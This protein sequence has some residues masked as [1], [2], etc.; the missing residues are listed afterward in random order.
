MALNNS[1]PISLGGATVG[2]SINLELG[3]AATA[4]ASIN[5]T[6]FRTLANVPSGTITLSNFYGKSSNSYW[7]L[8]SALPTLGTGFAVSVNGILCI[9]SGYPGG[10]VR[11]RDIVFFGSDGAFLKSTATNPPLNVS[12]RVQSFTNNISTSAPIFYANI[13]DEFGYGQ[14]FGSGGFA[15]FN[16]T[17]NTN[18]FPSNA[19]KRLGT[20]TAS[21]TD[22]SKR[23]L[24]VDASGNIYIVP[25]YPSA[26]TGKSFIYRSAYASLTSSGTERFSKA[27]S[28]GTNVSSFY[29]N[30]NYG[31]LRSDNQLV[32]VGANGSTQISLYVVN[33]SDGSSGQTYQYNIDTTRTDGTMQPLVD[34]SNNIYLCKSNNAYH[35]YIFKLNSA[36]A[37]VDAKYYIQPDGLAQSWS[38]TFEIYNDIIYTYATTGTVGAISVVAINTSTMAPI[39]SLKMTFS[40]M[41]NISTLFQTS[42]QSAIRVTSVGI[43]VGVGITKNGTNHACFIKVPLD[44]NISGTETINLDNSGT[45]CNVTFLYQTNAWVN[46]GLTFS[47]VTRQNINF[48]NDPV[49]STTG[50]TPATGTTPPNTLSPF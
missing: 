8:A 36:Y 29:Q 46:G 40:N 48:F 44:G 49:S 20:G 23:G 39:W 32:V 26:G 24:M 5:S 27:T 18:L 25:E 4:V 35:P 16:H 31:A 45:N 2:Q 11:S 47:F 42:R 14:G 10:N 33:T 50:S 43:Y 28:S 30:R 6:P 41:D 12:V 37:T 38:P 34:S 13:G 15:P 19:W 1:G 17:T 9:E 21:D 3:N 7:A 22:S